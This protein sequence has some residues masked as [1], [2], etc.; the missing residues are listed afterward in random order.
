MCKYESEYARMAESS[1]L[2]KKLHNPFLFEL[3]FLYQ[4]PV[5]LVK[6]NLR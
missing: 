1:Q 5:D 6:V 2:K 3:Q 4:S